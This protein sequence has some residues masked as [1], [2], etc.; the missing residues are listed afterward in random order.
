MAELLV[1][2]VEG[3]GGGLRSIESQGCNMVV[4]HHLNQCREVVITNIS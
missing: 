3:M 2:R 4:P 1:L